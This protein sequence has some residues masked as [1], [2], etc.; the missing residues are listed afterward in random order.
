MDEQ[1]LKSID[2]KLGTILKLTAL[3]IAKDRKLGEGA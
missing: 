2:Q 1:V 3:I